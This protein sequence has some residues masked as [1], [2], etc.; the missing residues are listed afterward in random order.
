MAHGSAG[1]KA[2]TVTRGDAMAR[3]RRTG[4]EALMRRRRR[5]DCRRRVG[6]GAATATRHDAAAR[7]RWQSEATATAPVR[8]GLEAG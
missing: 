3:Q 1:L 8:A 4:R 7:Q 2:A 6:D 5:R